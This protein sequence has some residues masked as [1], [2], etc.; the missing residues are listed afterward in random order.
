M[1]ATA[2]AML[3]MM[4]VGP[5]YA[6]NTNAT[7]TSGQKTDDKPMAW[8]SDWKEFTTE[9]PKTEGQESRTEQYM[10]KDVVWKGTVKKVTAPKEGKKAGAVELTMDPPLRLGDYT[11]ET[12]SLG[13]T[14]EEWPAW[15]QLTAAQQVVFQTRLTGPWPW[16][17]A[18]VMIFNMNDGNKFAQ[19]SSKGGKLIK[20]SP[21]P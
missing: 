5:V 18:P 11:I 16:A 14:D 4:L 15:A 20:A 13:P 6:D 12:I 1:K 9:Y 19:L 17:K 8:Q 2:A 3:A 7:A 21:K 10:E